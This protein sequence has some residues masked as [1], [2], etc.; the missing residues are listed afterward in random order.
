MDGAAAVDFT[1]DDVSVSESES[2]SITD[3]SGVVSAGALALL[4]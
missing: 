1:F 3:N 2:D 4:S